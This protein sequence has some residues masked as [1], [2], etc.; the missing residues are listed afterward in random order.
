MVVK[1]AWGETTG[2]KPVDTGTAGDSEVTVVTC[3]TVVA[4]FGREVLG[5]TEMLASRSAG[6]R[7]AE[8]L[9][10]RG[11]TVGNGGV[12]GSR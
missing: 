7:V 11:A 2:I 4:S 12:L 1:A 6:F 10:P 9:L 5:V 8:T 3:G